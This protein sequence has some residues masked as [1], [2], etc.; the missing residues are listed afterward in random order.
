MTGGDAVVHALERA[1]VPVVFG[2]A[3]VHNLPILDALTRSSIRLVPTR[4]ES[5]A[6]NHPGA[7]AHPVKTGGGSPSRARTYN[8][9]VNSR[10]L[11]H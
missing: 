3:S 10:V 5:G 2:V 1:G 7:P 4:T 11:Y 9:P 8:N 6:V